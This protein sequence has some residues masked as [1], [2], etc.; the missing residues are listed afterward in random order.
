MYSA[1]VFDMDGVIFDSEK[2]YRKYQLEEGRKYGIPDDIMIR[3]CE[4]IAGGTKETNKTKF[5]ELS[6]TD[7]DYYVFR[8]GVINSLDRHIEAHGVELKP[9]VLETLDFLKKN[10]IKIGLATST[11]KDRALGCLKK[12]DIV[13]YFDGMIFGDMVKK[14][15]PNPDIYLTACDM[16]GANPSQSIA[17]EDSINGI[18]SAHAA[19]MFPVMVIDLIQP[20]EEIQPYIYRIYDNMTQIKELF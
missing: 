5:E 10:N 19:G 3:I 4:N 18:K 15:K 2:I 8:E 9:G 13:K 17:V 7:I 14:G 6:G 1:V 12:H 16:I 11:S 20:T